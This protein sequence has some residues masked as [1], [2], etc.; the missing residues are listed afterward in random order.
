MA[1]W[2]ISDIMGIR[3][4]SFFI[5][6]GLI[7]IFD[8]DEIWWDL[9]FNFSRKM[10]ISIIYSITCLKKLLN[11]IKYHFILSYFNQTKIVIYI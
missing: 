10:N 11:I 3:V 5:L 1:D 8:K 6:I 4:Y 9:L 2:I 7:D